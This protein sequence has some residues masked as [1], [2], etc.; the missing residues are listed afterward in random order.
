MNTVDFT[1]LCKP[2][3]TL[4]SLQDPANQSFHANYGYPHQETFAG[5]KASAENCLLC[6][7]FH[8]A[9][10]AEIGNERMN[11]GKKYLVHEHFQ[12]QNS[13]RALRDAK[14]VLMKIETKDRA[15]HVKFLMMREG[16]KGSFLLYD[17]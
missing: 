17:M 7:R 4:V 13:L 10:I 1:A 5:L 2:C 8:K 6:E 11:A 12:A 14:V 15:N 16:G 9:Y 3:Q